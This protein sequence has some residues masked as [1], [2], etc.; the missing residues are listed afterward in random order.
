MLKVVGLD[1][2]QIG[3]GEQMRQVA[4]DRQ[5]LVMLRRLHGLR[6][7][8]NRPPPTLD[9]G[10]GGWVGLWRRRQD[11]F[12]PGK[13]LAVRLRRAAALGAGDGMAGHVAGRQLPAAPA[14]RL[15]DG[16]LDAPGVE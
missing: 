5:N 11:D 16:R 6:A 13:E 9:R 4:G 1:L 10:N 14:H 12:G 8:A 15:D 2:F 7:C 3:E